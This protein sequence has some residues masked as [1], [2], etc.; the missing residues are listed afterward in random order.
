MNRLDDK[1]HEELRLLVAKALSQV[2][3]AMI[4]LSNV[5]AML[6]PTPVTVRDDSFDPLDPANKA[7]DGKLTDRGIEICYRLFDRGENRNQVAS[8]MDIS[9]SAAKYRHEIWHKLGGPQR[10]KR[11]L[12]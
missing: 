6:D 12:D 1:S 3:S 10:E 9:F 5:A 8:L 2:T 11:P 7:A 4:A